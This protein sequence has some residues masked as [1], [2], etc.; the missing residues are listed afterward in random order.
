MTD[1][2]LKLALQNK[3][4]ILFM[5]LL[6]AVVGFISMLK[7]PIDAFPDVSPKLVRIFVEVNATAAEDIERL[8]TA[9]IEREMKKII[10]V[11]RV[12]SISSYGLS[13][14]RIYFDDN[15]NI[16]LARQYVSE[17]MKTAED[18]IPDFLDIPHG[19]EMGAISSGT[20]KIL[21][22]F[23]ES[24]NM[25][26]MDLRTLQDNVIKPSLEN[27][28]GVSE[29]LSQGGFVKRYRVNIVA[30][31]IEKYKV[32]IPEIIK[33]IKDS[34]LNVGAG[35]LKVKDEEWIVRSIGKIEKIEDLRNVFIKNIDGHKIFLKDVAEITFGAS[36]RRGVASI[37]GKNEIVTGSIYKS[38][39]ANSFKIIQTL[40]KNIDELNKRLP[41]KVKINIYYDQGMLVQKSIN[42]I[43]DA[44]VLGLILVS[45][46]SILFLRSIKNTALIL[47][48][49]PFSMFFSFV[50]LGNLGM[51]GD[52]ISLGGLAIGLGM[53][54]DASII[55]VEKLQYNLDAAEGEINLQTIIKDSYVQVARPIMFSIS[56]IIFTFIPIWTLTGVEGK[57]FKPLAVSITSAMFA[58]LI[59]ALLIIP[60]IFSLITK[61]KSKKSENFKQENYFI[62]VYRKMLDVFI[63]KRAVIL[64]I[65][66]V[67]ILVGGILFA[68]IGKVFMPIM[69]EGTIH[70]VV[71]M[72]PNIALS[73]ISK[74]SRAIE[75]EIVALDEVK[76][77]VT[78]IGYGDVGPH[79]HHTNY[80]S[81]TVGLTPRSSWKTS[82]S[83]EDV[84]AKIYEKLFFVPAKSISFTQPIQHEVD[85]LIAGSGSQV[86]IKLFGHD[87]VELSEL[88]NRVKNVI[89]KIEGVKDL[90]IDQII[91]QTQLK[92]KVNRL[93]LAHY[94]LSMNAVQKTINAAIG[95]LQIG[96]ILDGENVFTIEARLE[97]SSRND[98]DAIN[99]LMIA[100]KNEKIV[101][102]KDVASIEKTKGFMQIN[103]EMGNRYVKVQCN[104]RGRDIGSF[105]DE[106][107]G[108]VEK[109]IDM[110]QGYFISWGG[111]FELQKAAD[112]RF[113]VVIPL[114]L[115]IIALLLA[116]FH[117]NIA[118]MFLIF[119]NIPFSVVGGVCFLYLFKQNLSIPSTIGFI[120]LFG[121][122]LQDGLV[123]LN[124]FRYLIKKGTA[125]KEAVIEGCVSKVRPV[126]MTTLTTSF[127]LV[128]L[129]FSSGVGA[130]IQKPLAIVVVGGL[131]SSTLLTLFIIPTSYYW[132]FSKSL[133]RKS[134]IQKFE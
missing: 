20:G 110:P 31:N 55:M 47:C 37:N 134:L 133:S 86:V 127:A 83:Q 91:G 88:S 13:T 1:F 77:A 5:G 12:K 78:D 82:K 87:M 4:T 11:K 95:G 46:I 129:L 7:I 24:E 57:M 54:I 104:V 45:I 17:A 66:V 115:I 90:Y 106:V 51:S 15:V 74:F 48:S 61:I 119:L 128:P 36:E 108:K 33:H 112:K 49:I 111:Q 9:P 94:D 97:E 18:Q 50:I 75:K 25:Q 68:K 69:E 122:A 124:R 8:V 107:R 39:G 21:A 43:R 30:K 103:R 2:I 19:I 14:I 60:A 100:I 130:E 98:V 76:Y 123:L 42:T 89:S 27:V 6:L 56:I 52:L 73:E 105:V 85:D 113:A 121:I 40:K 38:P 44:L 117:N 65:C 3:K 118:E 28:D 58:S 93:K 32:T 23:L 126:L 26:L 16:Q 67:F 80:A 59:Y 63:N 34:S 72:D 99:N 120:A 109:N 41:E 132:I 62:K 22:Y 125:L 10:S 29:V 71:H 35:L 53:I 70:V 79:V 92:I 64:P 131:L 114:T 81:L 102:L 116:R 96:N 84:M 101:R